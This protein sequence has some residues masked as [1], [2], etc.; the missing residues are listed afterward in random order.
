MMQKVKYWN[1]RILSTHFIDFAEKSITTC[2]LCKNA[3]GAA[4]TQIESTI[5]QFIVTIIE[6]AI[7]GFVDSA[8]VKSL[9]LIDL[10]LKSFLQV[11][12]RLNKA[13]EK[14]CVDEYEPLLQ[15][16]FEYATNFT[17]EI[18]KYV[19]EQIPGLVHDN[20][21]NQLNA[22]FICEQLAACP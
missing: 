21:V 22:T 11:G 17:T 8:E 12:E 7:D 19:H 15:K 9:L 6:Q 2:I 18:P 13:C 14:Y 1:Y 10:D 4:L 16:C 20:I 3:V 5:E